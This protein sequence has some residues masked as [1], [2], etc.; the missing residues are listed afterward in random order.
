MTLAVNSRGNSNCNVA[1]TPSCWVRKGSHTG[2]KRNAALSIS[3]PVSFKLNT[4]HTLALISRSAG[5]PGTTSRCGRTA[6]D[7][8]HPVF[9]DTENRGIYRKGWTAVTKHSTPWLSDAPPFEEDIWELYGPDDWTQ[10]HN[11]ASENP[12]KLAELQRLL[13]EAV[14]YN[15]LPL[16]DRSVE[17]VNLRRA[18]R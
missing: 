13:I 5:P 11:I 16:D 9:R 6:R 14:K 2:A 10:A 7:T 17:R 8:R 3:F 1:A 18:R 12:D 4:S 15:V